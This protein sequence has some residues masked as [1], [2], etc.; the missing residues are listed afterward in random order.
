V[1]SRWKDLFDNTLA[2]VKSG[3]IA[4][5][6]LDD[7]V[8]RILRVKYLSGLFDKGAPKRRPLA[9]AFELLGSPAHR[10]VAREA[11]SKS[12]VLL[13]NDNR[14]LPLKP[15]MK[16]LV[17]GD[18]ADNIG[19]QAGGWTLSWQGSASVPRDL[20]PGATSI[21]DGIKAVDAKA[22]L[23][24][25]GSFADKPDAAIVVFGENPYA[26]FNGDL[27]TLDYQPA[28]KTDLAL[29]KKLKAAGIPTV[30]VFLSGRPRGVNAEINAS[31]A[32]VAAWQPGSEGAAVADLLF[33]KDPFS[34]KLSFTWQQFPRGFGLTTKDHP[35]PAV[36]PEQPGATTPRAEIVRA[37]YV[38]APWS[39]TLGDK[40]G[41]I[42]ATLAAQTSGAGAVTEHMVIA[43]NA[44]S[45]LDLLWSGKAKG[46]A[47]FSALA[48]NW[49][50]L[51]AGEPVLQMRWRVTEPA[52]G[53][54]TLGGKP[55]T[56]L[57][58]AAGD[59]QVSRFKLSCFPEGPVLDLVT[60]GKLGLSIADLEIVADT[61]DAGCP[62]WQ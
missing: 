23:S 38:A 26:E 22:V 51:V 59:W 1:S 49:R 29:L 14:L 47:N 17:T 52:T 3:R 27:E 40:E 43:G 53:A 5:A 54:V 41:G 58:S 16:L 60:D 19:K 39:L 24:P 28:A 13:K 10:A 18:G 21:W 42:R 7:A 33:G 61:G 15:G 48:A 50:P 35:K 55:V 6:R 9:G 56:A 25:D 32:F 8:R 31:T 4:E 11:A 46:G 57:M 45:S 62:A 44:P 20:F 2:Q 12:M 30:A 36:L 34:G 37:G